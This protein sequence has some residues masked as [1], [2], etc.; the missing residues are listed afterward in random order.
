MTFTGQATKFLTLCLIVTSLISC[1]ISTTPPIVVHP[2]YGEMAADNEIF[3]QQASDC[4]LMASQGK[5]AML[6]SQS[7]KAEAGIAF[8]NLFLFFN[9][10]ADCIAVK[11]WA[12]KEDS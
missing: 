3:V 9:Q 11:G 8:T 1:S 5:A 6:D 7:T 4:A 10:H 12:I 2:E